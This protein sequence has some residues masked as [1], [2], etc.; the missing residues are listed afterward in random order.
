VLFVI[1]HFTKYTLC[2]HTHLT[3]LSQLLAVGGVTLEIYV[4]S[5]AC[6]KQMCCTLIKYNDDDDDDDD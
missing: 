4:N 6:E 2:F 5:T 3:T 1:K